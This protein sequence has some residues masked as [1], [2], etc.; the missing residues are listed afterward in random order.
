[1]DH[2]QNFLHLVQDAKKRIKEISIDRLT[3][4]IEENELFTLID[5]REDN[6]W[7][8]GH[9]LGAHHI[10]RGILERDIE[11]TILEKNTPLILY[12]GSGYRSALAADSLMKMGYSHVFSLKG[13]I[14]AWR[15]YGL[16]ITSN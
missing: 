7:N 11:K 9:L 10:P 14:T 2:S 12:C 8:S 1:M 13:G 5:V 16:P 15:D 3:K 4:L 6:E